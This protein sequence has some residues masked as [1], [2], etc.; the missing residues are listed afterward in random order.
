LTP[1][2]PAVVGTSLITVGVPPGFDTPNNFRQ[3]AVTVNP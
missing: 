3:I 1:F 2:D